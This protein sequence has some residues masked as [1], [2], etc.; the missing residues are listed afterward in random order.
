MEERTRWGCL[1]DVLL[2]LLVRSLKLRFELVNHSLRDGG[3]PRQLDRTVDGFVILRTSRF[4][5]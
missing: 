4:L 1:S 2:Q 3:R 5:S